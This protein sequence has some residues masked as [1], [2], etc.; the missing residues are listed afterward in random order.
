MVDQT[1]LVETMML[2]A[3]RRGEID[4]YVLVSGDSHFLPMVQALRQDRKKVIVAA[5]PQSSS[6]ILQR[7][8]SQFLALPISI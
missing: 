2:H 4:T 8:A 1:L 6:I 7:A 3:H 5:L